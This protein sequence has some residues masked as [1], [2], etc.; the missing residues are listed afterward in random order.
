MTH[1]EK[2]DRIEQIDARL[3][4]LQRETKQLQA[5]KTDV[6]MT[7]ASDE[8]RDFVPRRKHAPAT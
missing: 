4:Q 6:L 5:E 3:E 1:S 8:D 7:R 2:W